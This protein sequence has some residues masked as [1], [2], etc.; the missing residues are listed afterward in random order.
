[1][2]VL[3]SLYMIHPFKWVDDKQTPRYDYTLRKECNNIK[4][5]IPRTLET[6][7]DKYI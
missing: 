1:V 6:A 5:Y 3:V 2:L 7:D 4:S